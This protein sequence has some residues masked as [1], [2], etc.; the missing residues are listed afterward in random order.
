[1][2][3]DSYA[4]DDTVAAYSNANGHTGAANQDTHYDSDTA[5]YEDSDAITHQDCNSLPFGNT[6]GNAARGPAGGDPG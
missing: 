3:A 6:Y 1:M 2:A 5:A 4:N